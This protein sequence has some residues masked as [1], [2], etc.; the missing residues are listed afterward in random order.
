M[1]KCHRKECSRYGI[2]LPKTDFQ[3]K[4]SSSNGLDYWCRECRNAGYLKVKERKRKPPVDCFLESA[5]AY[6][7]AHPVVRSVDRD[8]LVKAIRGDEQITI[9]I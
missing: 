4:S 5:I 1:P 3:Q 9:S 6:N 7:K 2:E 8:K